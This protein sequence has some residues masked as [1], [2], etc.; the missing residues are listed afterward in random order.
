MKTSFLTLLLVFLGFNLPAVQAEDACSD[1]LMTHLKE[2]SSSEE[3]LTNL[4]EHANNIS[5]FEIVQ[6]QKNMTKRYLSLQHFQAFFYDNKNN[7]S[8][9]VLATAVAIF[10]YSSVGKSIFSNTDLRRVFMGFANFK[11]YKLDD[12]VSKY[13]VY[14]SNAF[15]EEAL[16][17]IASVG[18]VLPPGVSFHTSPTDYDPNLYAFSD[19]AIKGT[20]SVVAGAARV[21]GFISDQLKW[22]Q[23]RIKNNEEAIKTLRANLKPLDL[24][25]ETRKF[26]LSNFTIPGHW[27]HVG[28]WLG[29]KEELITMGIWEQPFFTP[30][31]QYVENG[32]N[33][34]EI[35]KEGLN[36]QGIDTFINLDE[37]AVTRIKN[38]IDRAHSVYEGLGEQIEKKYDFKFDARTAEKITCAELIAFSYGDIKWPVTK[39]LFQY[40][41]RPDDLAVT[42][43]DPLYNSEF[44][45]YFK[46]K[47]EKEGGGFENMTFN[48]WAKLYKVK[49]HL[50]PEQL[51]ADKEKEAKK[52]REMDERNEFNK[53]YSGA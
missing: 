51:A 19:T 39:T 34:V 24:V 43:L 1:A 17:E 32:K 16:E 3:F 11:A 37:I 36:F 50:T 7:C 5:P 10:D 46:G 20:T 41:L 4:G 6:M 40:S 15:I 8:P 31:K 2:I 13:K 29:T 9:K 14:T 12:Y 49:E 38:I 21:W 53:L 28:I 52:K 23:G 44:V 42:T 27:G 47:K 26:T 45:L 35:R 30:F 25:F 22:R 48:Q 18:L 33:I